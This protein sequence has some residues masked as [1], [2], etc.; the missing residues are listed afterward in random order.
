[1]SG[2]YDGQGQPG[3]TFPLDGYVVYADFFGRDLTDVLIYTD[4]EAR[5]YSSE[6]YDLSQRPSGQQL[7]HPKRL[8]HQT[9]YPGGEYP[10]E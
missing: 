5:I 3:V 8:S 6:A 4:E 9:L 7:Q 2:L 10:S 1:M